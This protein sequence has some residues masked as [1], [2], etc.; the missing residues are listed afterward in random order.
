MCNLTKNL[1]FPKMIACDDNGNHAV[2]VEHNISFPLALAVDWI[3]GLLFWI[4]DGRAT[5]SLNQKNLYL[6]SAFQCSLKIRVFSITGAKFG[7]EGSFTV[8][9]NGKKILGHILKTVNSTRFRSSSQVSL[10]LYCTYRPQ[11]SWPSGSVTT[12]QCIGR[13]FKSQSEIKV[14]QIP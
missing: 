12:L 3:H 4:D 11:D 13:G 6:Y 10:D 1:Q 7:R 5:V 9:Q 2:L 14:D 8:D